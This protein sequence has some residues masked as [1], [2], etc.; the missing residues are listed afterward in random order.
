VS[1]RYIQVTPLADNVAI[2]TVVTVRKLRM[3]MHEC[4]GFMKY[5]VNATHSHTMSVMLIIDNDNSRYS[6]RLDTYL[7]LLLLQLNCDLSATFPRKFHSAG[8]LSR[9]PLSIG[10]RNNA[11]I[12]MICVYIIF[13]YHRSYRS[14]SLRATFSYSL[15]IALTHRSAFFDETNSGQ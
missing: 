1:S 13:V 15:D 3:H 14:K 11:G 8:E 9:R 2:L 10:Q 7:G 12:Q 4:T 6:N 5:I